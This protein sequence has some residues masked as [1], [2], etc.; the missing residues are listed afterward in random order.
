MILICIEGSAAIY[1]IEFWYDRGLGPPPF[2][3]NVV[4]QNFTLST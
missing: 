3:Q 1:E 4:T 2:N